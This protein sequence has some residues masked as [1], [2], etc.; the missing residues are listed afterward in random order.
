MKLG[1]HFFAKHSEGNES[2]QERIVQGPSLIESTD[3]DNLLCIRGRMA[4]RRARAQ[5][6]QMWQCT[7]NY[8]GQR[9]YAELAKAKL[10]GKS[11]S[12]GRKG[13]GQEQAS[14]ADTVVWNCVK[15]GKVQVG[16]DRRKL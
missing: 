14:A 9:D 16:A 11:L 12:L 7:C 3:A 10:D 1:H 13:M 6:L 15:G 2:Q 4:G 5:M 8:S